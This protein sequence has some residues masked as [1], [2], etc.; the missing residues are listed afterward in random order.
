MKGN[1]QIIAELQKRLAEELTAIAQYQ[2]HRSM[3]DIQG[4][5]KLVAEIDE[6]IEDERKHR[7]LLLQRLRFFG[8]V[9]AVGDINTTHDGKDAVQVHTLNQTA[10]QNA[11]DRYDETVKLCIQH[12]DTGTRTMIES[13]IADE[14]EHILYAEQEL[15]QIDQMTIQNY[16]SAKI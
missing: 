9:P 2:A 8:I 7:D 14:E 16:M 15:T 3:F 11:I 12:G 1:A 13:I 10:E 5:V 4:Y 6:K